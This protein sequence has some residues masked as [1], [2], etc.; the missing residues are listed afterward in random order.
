MTET[1]INHYSY[2][3]DSF[4]NFYSNVCRGLY[5]LD[6]Q[7]HGGKTLHDSIGPLESSRSGQAKGMQAFLRTWFGQ[8]F[9]PFSST[10]KGK[11][12]GSSE[13]QKINCNTQT[14]PHH[15]KTK[16]S[17]QSKKSKP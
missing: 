10:G 3:L 13:K 8:D 6:G 14:P 16:Q 7:N 4:N 15:P 17:K 9:S 11:P 2:P 1:D 12:S 5:I